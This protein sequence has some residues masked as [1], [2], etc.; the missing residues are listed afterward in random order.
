MI[1]G[2]ENYYPTTSKEVYM[3]GEEPM[4]RFDPGVTIRMELAKSALTGLL[5]NN[6]L[7][8]WKH[9]DFAREAFK[10]A[11]AMIAEYNK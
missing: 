2:E 8:H 3:P 11:D 4:I 1:T 7:L 10:M 6:K 5:V 9:E